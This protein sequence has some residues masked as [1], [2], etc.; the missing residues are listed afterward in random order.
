MKFKEYPYVRPDREQTLH[1]ME[2]LNVRLAGAVD[3]EAFLEA[4]EDYSRLQSH[5]DTAATLAQ[6]RHTIDTRD[7]FYT[8]ESEYFDEVL[9]VFTTAQTKIVK[10]ILDSPFVDALKS[11]VAPTWFMKNENLLKTVAPEI[12][13]DLQLENQLASQYQKLI[14]TAQIDFDGRTWTLAGLQEKMNDE[15]QSVRKAAHKAYWG[16]YADHEQEIGNLYDQLVK[17]R[18]RM[19]RKMGF[20]N[21][22]PFGY[23]RMNRLDYDMDDVETYRK[24]ILRDVV[25]VAM[26]LY[27]AQAGRLGYE[28]ASLPVWDEKIGYRSG[29]PKP[30]HSEEEMVH[31]AL[32][33]YQELSPQTGEFFEKMCEDE[34]L[35]L[36]SK[37]GK[38]GGGYCTI[39]ADQK[40][41]FIFA[42]FNK[43]QHDVEVLTHEA[44][45]AFQCWTSRNIT[46]VD[47]I[48]PTSESAEIT[49]MSMEFFTWPWMRDFFEEDTD[50]Y[51]ASHLGGAV[52]FLPYGV[53]VDHY[54]HEVYRHPEW[55]N[56]QR[57][58]AWRKLEKQYLP[59]KDYS[60]IDFLERG[61][62]WM[63]QLHIFMDPLYYIDYTLAQVV[64]LQ[65]WD[66]LQKQDP[67]AFEDYLAV[68]KAGGTRPFR[69]LVKL[70]N[71]NVPFEDGCLSRTMETVQE[72]YKNHDVVQD[73]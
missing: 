16:W 52:K 61:G 73:A 68:C 26:E 59:H 23:L 20:D 5:L 60:E 46:P 4:F 3:E 12:V 21:Y 2:E 72:W 48:F 64:A 15:D 22:L 38:A 34:L 7:E 30:K 47:L 27:K 45:H 31:R 9:P 63:V 19:A 44:G 11:K 28:S 8:A 66:R 18:T 40:A 69:E 25:P 43:T 53:L 71:V 37:P 42:N 6:V 10:T 39:I 51:Y 57:M 32:K 17:V 33:M 54:Q 41:P 36:A 62:W 49:S 24:N 35:D 58:A 65:F 56:D 29:A 14:A 13:E 50:K 55:T 1:T 70:A 67:K